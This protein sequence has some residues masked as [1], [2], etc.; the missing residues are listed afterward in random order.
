MYVPNGQEAPPEPL[1]T[2]ALIGIAAGGGG[3][4]LL[5]IVLIACFMFR[6]KK[7]AKIMTVR[8]EGGGYGKD[9]PQAWS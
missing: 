9:V 8:P 3:G 7:R 2:G 6:K 5:L 4:S 1:S